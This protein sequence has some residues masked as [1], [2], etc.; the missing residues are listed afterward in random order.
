MV[1][2]KQDLALLKAPQNV[3]PSAG[4]GGGS[5]NIE[6]GV[7]LVPEVGPELSSVD[8]QDGIVADEISVYTVRE[9]DSL[10]SIA[11]MFGVSSNTILW[12][13]DLKRGSALRPGTTLTILPVSGIRYTVKRG[14]TVA[15]I[16]KK[17]KANEDDIIAFNELSGSLTSGDIIMIPHG[18]PLEAEAVKKKSSTSKVALQN[19]VGTSAIGSLL[20][21][22]LGGVKTQGIHG[23]NAVDFGA[24]VGTKVVAAEDG[25][26]VISKEGGWN[27]GYG[28]YI[29]IKHANGVQTLYA[30]LSET[31]AGVGASVSAGE[32]IGYTG[33][34]GRS[35]GPHLHFE[36]R[37]AKNPF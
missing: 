11:N 14:D 30:H 31:V 13:N 32:V 9:G 37:G 20:R 36:V 19:P 7:A 35:T 23:Y 1:T 27:G 15:A 6:D 24:P 2:P 33:N 12:A 28:S 18:T 17:Y 4:R 8:Y 26:V 5:I 21:P 3:N 22:L 16:A 10:S 34:T 25:E 29:V